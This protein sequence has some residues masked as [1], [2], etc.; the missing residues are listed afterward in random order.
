[1]KMMLFGK[2]IEGYSYINMVYIIVGNY[3]A[4]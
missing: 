3:I 4:M 2:K 1:M